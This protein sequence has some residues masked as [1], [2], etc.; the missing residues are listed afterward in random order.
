MLLPFTE[1][2]RVLDNQ[3][4]ALPA[5]L[6]KLRERG[7]EVTVRAE[8]IPEYD[9]VLD[10]NPG[11]HRQLGRGRVH[12]VADEQHALAIPRAGHEQGMQ[13]P[14]IDARRIGYPLTHPGDD[15]AVLGEEGLDQRRPFLLRRPCDLWRVLDDED[16]HFVICDRAAADLV[17]WSVE[18]GDAVADLVGSLQRHTPHGLAGEERLGHA[19]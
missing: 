15:A 7:T 12:G 16:V 8:G 2:E 11:A 5:A 17:A 9:G 6:H 1:L 4:A 19:G 13:G 14:P 18:H 3:T 10:G